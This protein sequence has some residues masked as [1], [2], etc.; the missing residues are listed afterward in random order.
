[1][2]KKN[3]YQVIGYVRKSPGKEDVSTR[4]RLFDS[5]V[6]TLIKDSSVDMVFVS[7]S[8]TSKQPFADRD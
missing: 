8:S 6:D 2:L 3:E 7:Y 1:R 5:M 4:L